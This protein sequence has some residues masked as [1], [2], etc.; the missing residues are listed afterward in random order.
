MSRTLVWSDSKEFAGWWFTF[1][2]G[3][4]VPPPRAVQSLFE[5]SWGE[6]K[7]EERTGRAVTLCAL[8][9]P[10][11]CVSTAARQ[12]SSRPASIGDVI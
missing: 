3:P 7:R 1:L 2:S 5:M 6:K 8:R 12:Q 4:S 10:Q 9:K 11:F